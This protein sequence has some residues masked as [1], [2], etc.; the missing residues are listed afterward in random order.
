MCS[1]CFVLV[2]QGIPGFMNKRNI[3]LTKS[4]GAAVPPDE[5]ER[6]GG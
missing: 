4:G 1:S 6:G 2:V 5:C 3:E